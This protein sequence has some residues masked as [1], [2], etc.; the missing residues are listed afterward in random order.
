[1]LAPFLSRLKIVEGED[2]EPGKVVI[3][4]A[5]VRGETSDDLVRAVAAG[6]EKAPQQGLLLLEEV[7]GLA[8]A[9]AAGHA[10]QL[11]SGDSSGHPDIHRQVDAPPG[12]LPRPAGD[13]FR[14]EDDLSR[15]VRG[16]R[17]LLQK[18]REE[19]LL[20]DRRMPLGMSADSDI[21]EAVIEL[22]QGDE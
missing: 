19:R 10:E 1:L 2:V 20:G 17:R 15:D 3:R 6:H 7:R 16:Q 12:K 5:E 4:F 13:D 21:G 11:L 14:I 8:D 18:R 9:K 22:M